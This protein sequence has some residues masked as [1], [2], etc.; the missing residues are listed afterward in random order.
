MGTA[1]STYVIF[2]PEGLGCSAQAKQ[3]CYEGPEGL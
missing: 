2:K 3:G 1:V